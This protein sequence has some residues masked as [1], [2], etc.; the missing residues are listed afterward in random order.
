M[1]APATQNAKLGGQKRALANRLAAGDPDRLGGT[2]TNAASLLDPGALAA[3]K[4]S[5][6]FE[7]HLG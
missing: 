7:F 4:V 2:P 3:K 1:I 5:G 6:S